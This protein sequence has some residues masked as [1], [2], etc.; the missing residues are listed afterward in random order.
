LHRT[1]WRDRTKSGGQV[2]EQAIHLLDLTRYF[3]GEP[4]SVFS[5]QDNLFHRN[6]TDYTIEDASGTLIRFANG[7]I[8]VVT[9]TN[10]AIPGRW[11][12]DW[13]VVTQEL[14]ADFADAN[15]ALT[16]NTAQLP[17][18]SRT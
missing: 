10:G 6:V 12:S 14:T 3:L 18:K 5:M 15:H 16:Y 11:D 17:V 4:V 1:W 13:R 7:S 9:A 8:A 2:V